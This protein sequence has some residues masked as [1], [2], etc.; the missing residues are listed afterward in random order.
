MS[1]YN[2]SIKLE[3]CIPGSVG[4]IGRS[5]HLFSMDNPHFPKIKI[6]SPAE[7]LGPKNQEGK[8]IDWTPEDLFVGSVAVCFFTTFVAMAEKMRLDYERILIEAKGILEKSDDSGLIIT[9]IEENV[10]LVIKSEEFRTKA[11]KVLE[12]AE[13]NCLI[14]NSIKSKVIL[15]SMVEIG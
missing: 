10:K 4:E 8:S 14:A 15:N 11:I 2:Y 5:G 6:Q 13:K 12:N 1:S 9:Q 7:F 3:Q